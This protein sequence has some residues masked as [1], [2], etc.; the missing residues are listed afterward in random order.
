M[1]KTKIETKS[2]RFVQDIQPS[3]YLRRQLDLVQFSQKCNEL[4]TTEEF[5]QLVF[6]G[7]VQTYSGLVFRSS[8]ASGK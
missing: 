7:T 6:F 4:A 8:T 5:E 2:H 3:Y 1:V